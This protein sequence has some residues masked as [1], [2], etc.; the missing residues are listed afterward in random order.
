MTDYAQWGP[1]AR[2]VGTWEGDEGLDVAFAHADGRVKD[3]PY[4]ERTVLNPFVDVA[5]RDAYN[6]AEPGTGTPGMTATG[7]KVSQ[8]NP[9]AAIGASFSAAP[10]NRA[11]SSVLAGGDVYGKSPSVAGAAGAFLGAP[12]TPDLAKIQST[13]Q[14]TLGTLPKKGQPGYVMH[15]RKVRAASSRR[16]RLAVH[17]IR[18]PKVRK[19]ARPR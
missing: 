10:L 4:R 8:V 6:A 17:R 7:Q 19:P 9:A 11:L 2:L 1:L 12:S 16:V 13:V 5:L 18:L 14:K 3:T 15:P